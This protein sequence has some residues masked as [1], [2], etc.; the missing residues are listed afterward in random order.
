MMSQIFTN[1]SVLDIQSC[2]CLIYINVYVHAFMKYAKKK[3]NNNIKFSLQ[4][5]ALCHGS[6]SDPCDQF[7]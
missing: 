4:G 5:S 3:K 1:Y 2:R 7:E 6:T